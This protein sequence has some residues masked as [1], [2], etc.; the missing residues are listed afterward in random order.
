[1]DKVYRKYKQAQLNPQVLMDELGIDVSDG[2]TLGMGVVRKE[3]DLNNEEKQYLLAIERGDMATV[4]N[5]LDEAQIYF[6]LNI[7][8][9]DPLGRTGILIAIENENI[10]MIELL[11]QYNV[12]L[13]DALLHAINEENVE[14]VELIL[15]HQTHRKK[16]LS[17]ISEDDEGFLGGTPSSSFTPDITPIILAAHRDNYEIIKILLDRGEVIPKPH[18]VRC[19]CKD[20][21]KSSEEDSLNHS[22]SRINAYRA[23]A[24]PSL[25][26]LSSKDPILT[27]FELSW[28]LKRLSRFENEFKDDYETLSKKCQEFAVALLDQTRG[29]A[30]LKIILNHDTDGPA[31]ADSDHMALSRLKLAIKFKQ[32]KFVSHPNCQQLLASLWYEGLPGFRRRP[33]A[34][35]LICTMVV[36]FNF[37]FLSLLYIMA[38]KGC[39]GRLIRRPFIKFICHSA[40]YM[41]FLGFL[42]LASQR[43][44]SLTLMMDTDRMK[45][46]IR[47]APPTVIEWIIMAY[48]AGLIWAEVKQLWDEG[49]RAYIHDMWN[50]LDFITNSLYLA[51]IALRAVAYIKVEQEKA[52]GLETANL[53]RKE[54][55]AYDPNLIAEGLFATAN[56]FSSLKLIY[57]FTV[58]PHL[59]PLQI[60]LGRMVVDILKFAFVFTLVLFAFACG[61][62][63]LY[64]YYSVTR[65]DECQQPENIQKQMCID[66]KYKALL[67]LFEIMQTLYWAIYGLI[68]LEHFE[69]QEE[70][71][72]TELL[73][74]LMFGVYS[75]I[76]I[77]VLLSMLISMMSNS[78]NHIT[79]L[80]WAIYGLV[81]LE[82]FALQE[83]HEFTQLL[84]KLMFG[85]Y[86]AIAIV[87]LLNMLIA[88]MSNSYHSIVD[89]AD[90]EWKFA[91]SKLWMSYFE[92]GGTVPPPFNIIPTPKTIWYILVWFKTRMCQCTKK[93]KRNKWQSIRRVVKK[94]NEREQ[95]YQ[96]I[97]RNVSENEKRYQIVMRDLIK[98]Y[99]MQQQRGMQTEGVTEDDLNEIKQDISAFRYELLEI[100]RN[101]GMKTPTYSKNQPGKGSRLRRKRSQMSIDRMKKNLQ[102]E[103]IPEGDAFN[104]RFGKKENGNADINKKEELQSRLSQ[105]SMDSNTSGNSEMDSE[106]E[107]DKDKKEP[108]RDS[109]DQS[110]QRKD[111]GLGES[112]EI[113]SEMSD[114]NSDTRFNGNGG[115]RTSIYDTVPEEKE[116]NVEDVNK[117]EL[118]DKNEI[119]T[120]K[121]TENDSG[122]GATDVESPE[123][124]LD[125]SKLDNQASEK[126]VVAKRVSFLSSESNK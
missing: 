98:R 62:N 89:Q 113:Q 95:K 107:I 116:T 122:N 117:S 48:V 16:D 49:A 82:H 41:S 81:D 77:V 53:P 80:Y 39:F 125:P 78:Y 45:S 70:H 103:P 94:V 91:R 37:P 84:G 57:I 100:L 9:V 109:S 92:E 72:F 38:P 69:L 12:E 42:I 46:E 20:C 61:I 111:E 52:I 99:I 68:D 88:M 13:G 7:N 71:V 3:I 73:G 85:V 10:E 54:W 2:E 105:N 23:L 1:M 119:D 74:K 43:I 51:T 35:K 44:A 24:S 93:Q 76:A 65:Q 17:V 56:I 79:T 126:G 25:V 28:E 96:K 14:A 124:A 60:S 50:I 67:D 97:V 31:N 102:M 21:K 104:K 29:S 15:S 101:N 33:T 120:T 87:V 86:S 36:A 59:G 22:R 63:Q 5:Y 108:E 30:E 47:G 123:I 34:F 11:L 75:A 106:K 26:A 114:S 55:D 118:N 4:K 110:L 8:C 58:N 6:N 121:S 19:S 66:Q 32:K 112:F 90:T 40:S 115:S 18:D 83:K 64:W 27:T